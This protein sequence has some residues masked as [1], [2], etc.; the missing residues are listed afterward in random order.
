MAKVTVQYG[1]VTREYSAEHTLETAGKLMSANLILTPEQG[2]GEGNI[3]PGT[4][5]VQPDTSNITVTPGTGYDGMAQVVVGSI[6]HNLSSIAANVKSGTTLTISAASVGTKPEDVLVSVAGTMPNAIVS[7]VQGSISGSNYTQGHVDVKTA[8]YINADTIV[9]GAVF[10]NSSHSGHTYTDIS[11]TSAAPVLVEGGYLYID[12]GYTDDVKISLA[13]LVPEGATWPVGSSL[14]AGMVSGY[15]A[16]DS[17]GTLVTGSITDKGTTGINIPATDADGNVPIDPGYYSGGTVTTAK[18]TVNGGSITYTR[19]PQYDGAG[20]YK[21][22]V[23]VVNSGVQSAGWISSST[24]TLN[25]PANKTITLNAPEV[26]VTVASASVQPVISRDTVTSGA[27]DAASGAATGTAPTTGVYVKVVTDSTTTYANG[28]LTTTA[29]YVDGNNNHI[30]KLT[31]GKGTVTMNASAAYVPIK[32]TTVSAPTATVSVAT[33]TAVTGVSVSTVSIP[34]G[35][36]VM[37]WAVTAGATYQSA[38]GYVTD[39]AVK[40][41]T[42]QT[43]NIDI[44][45]FVL[46]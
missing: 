30:V 41:A 33:P 36:T 22:P 39:T 5:Y 43:A 37:R 7:E 26:T 3:E 45:V 40:N 18:A 13:K 10:R 21:I 38:E 6:T 8:G 27:T 19:S 1:T 16:Y 14:S 35:T 42:N 17:D 28:G 15:S 20:S 9:D 24:G 34:S 25:V 32:T 4:R 31:L 23:S 2:S 46:S 44:P 11:N 12:K 29:G